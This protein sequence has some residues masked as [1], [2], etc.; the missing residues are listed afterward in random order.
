MLTL[1]TVLTTPTVL[2]SGWYGMNFKDMPE[3]DWRDGYMVISI[4]TLITTGGMV[5]WMK[6]K[7]W[8]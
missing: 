2:V 7:R 4:L 3:L 5:A 6:F 1:L 8:L